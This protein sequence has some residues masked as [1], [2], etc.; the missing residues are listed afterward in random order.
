MNKPN[1]K[2]LLFVLAYACFSCSPKVGF[3]KNGKVYHD[4]YINYCYEE[5]EVYCQLFGDFDKSK[6]S[7]YKIDKSLKKILRK[8][9]FNSKE[10]SLL[11]QSSTVLEPKYYA[12]GILRKKIDEKNYVP[13]L[14]QNG[15]LLT[16]TIFVKN[17]VIYETVYKLPNFFFSLLFYE[18]GKVIKNTI[19][20][21]RM[22]ELTVEALKNKNCGRINVADV[23]N[24]IFNY[25]KK[26]NYLT[27]RW[28]GKEKNRYADADTKM[29][30]YNQVLATYMNFAQV[31][32]NSPLNFENE[33]D[34]NYLTQKHLSI[35][36]LQDTLKNEKLILFNEA[37]HLAKHKYLV[38][39]LLK[40]LYDKGFRYL[41]LESFYEDENFKISKVPTLDNGF[42]LRDPVVG[43]L[44]REAKKIGYTVFGYDSQDENREEE[45]A[46]NIYNATFKLNPNAKVLILGGYSHIEES[47]DWMAGK[48]QNLF[49]INPFTVNQTCFENLSS[50]Y[51]IIEYVK[52]ANNVK[53]DLFIINSLKIGNNCFN[54]KESKDVDVHIPI[55]IKGNEVLLIYNSNEFYSQERPI[56]VW[57]KSIENKENSFKIN[58]CKEDYKIIIKNLQ[59]DVL[60]EADL[61]NRK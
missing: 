9:N 18:K 33:L 16:K 25:D 44:V 38:G 51:D 34:N 19:D 55:E 60:Y 31:Y 54:S 56:P 24:E 49:N 26:G 28:L 32:D 47:N 36:K 50:K 43:N 29:S 35:E 59:N 8:I 4:G 39:I 37:H 17:I 27:Y 57:V 58:L 11:F 48:F 7:E 21:Q 52:N 45:Q 42:Y 53:S 30:V 41:G 14:T 10:D 61:K 5:K 6:F 12:V 46:K 22:R 23:A 3:L 20:Y 2:Y 15:V 1:Y 40:P 13:E